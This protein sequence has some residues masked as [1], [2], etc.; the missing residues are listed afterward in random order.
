MEITD[1]EI[2]LLQDT[3]VS[4]AEKIHCHT[5]IM[6]PNGVV[7]ASSIPGRT[8][9]IHSGAAKVISGEVDIFEVTPEMAE[10]SDI[11][12]EECNLPIEVNGQRIANIAITAPLKKS[13]EF[14]TI[15]QT[16]IETLLESQARQQKLAE[17]EQR[18]RDF[19]DSTADWFWEMGP[20][21][22]FTFFI[23]K[24]EE[25]LGLEPHEIIG[26]TRKELYSSHID[27]D[28]PKWQ[29]HLQRIKEHQ[30]FTDFELPWRRQDGETR[31]VSL[32]GMPRFNVDG[33]FLGYRGTG[34]DITERKL[35]KIAQRHRSSILELLARECPLKEI[36]ITLVTM[37]EEMHHG[38]LGSFLL[39][40]K[41][42]EHLI[43]G[44]APSLPDFYTAAI[45][46]TKIG[47][48]V[49]SCGTAAFTKE[50]VI[51]EDISTHPF[52]KNARGLAAK[53][54]LKACW[55][56]PILSVKDEVLGTFAMY[57]KETRKPT[58]DEL[59]FIY[60]KTNEY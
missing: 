17:S 34:Q 20:D 16:C 59:N 28:S 57:Y 55:S 7:L 46:R 58:Q 2:Q 9:K 51:I 21:L 29:K 11:M 13:R 26:K 56:Q 14:G 54:G 19:S 49:G 4:I 27:T 32:S 39:M 3:C 50:R 44:A 43:H 33:S 22:R 25:A 6:G 1:V 23:G 31:F 38:M 52:W 42:G 30:P 10:A 8:G 53:A 35:L 5:T 45:N 18:L 41:D 40:D 24:T 60:S 36:L 37:S 15:A 12:L 47:P 48:E